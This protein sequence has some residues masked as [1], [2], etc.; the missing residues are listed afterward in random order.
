M[1]IQKQLGR[2][3]IT[4]RTKS[5]EEYDLIHIGISRFFGTKYILSILNVTLI[6]HYIS[7]KQEKVFD[8]MCKSRDGWSEQDW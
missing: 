3:S 1:Y 4:L 8:N 2:L 5:T 7:E 6:V